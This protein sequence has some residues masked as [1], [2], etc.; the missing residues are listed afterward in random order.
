MSRVMTKQMGCCWI[1]T[2]FQENNLRRSFIP[3]T[4]VKNHYEMSSIF[5]RILVLQTAAI[6]TACF[7]KVA[8]GKQQTPV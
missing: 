4:G 7:L 5:Q 2:F 6:F 1:V 8:F 3:F